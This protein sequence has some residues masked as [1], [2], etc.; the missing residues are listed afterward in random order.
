[1]YAIR[2]YY[3]TQAGA[4]IDFSYHFVISTEEH[5]SGL[6]RY[7]REYG[8]P[9]FKIFMNN[10]GGEGARLGLPDIDD[11]FLFRLCEAAAS[12]G[13]MVCPHPET[14]EIAWVLRKRLEVQA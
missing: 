5:L 2:S 3:V 7:V 4:R 14:I 13:G 6:P 1:M 10:R 12:H 11:G 9:S 8:I